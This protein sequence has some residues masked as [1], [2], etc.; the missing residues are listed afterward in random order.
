M[1]IDLVEVRLWGDTVGVLQWEPERNLSVFEYD[2]LFIRSGLNVSPFEAPLSGALIEGNRSEAFDGLPPFIADSLPDRFGNAI[3]NAYFDKAGISKVNLTPLDRLSYIGERAM[4]A[5]TYHPVIENKKLSSNISLQASELVEAAR[6]ALSGHLIDNS[7]EATTALNNLLSVGIS[8]GGARAK[9]VINLNNQTGEIRSGQF[10]CEP[11]FEAWLIK[12]DGV[13]KD[14]ALGSSQHYCRIEYAYSLMAKQAGIE[15]SECCLFEEGGRAHFLTKRFDRDS[16]GEKIHMQTLCAMKGMDFNFNKSHSYEQYFDT[17]QQLLE[18]NS[19]TEQAI[20]RSFFNIIARNQDDHTKNLSFLM[21]KQGRWSLAP[22]Y[23]VTYAFNPDNKWT[24]AHQM[25]LNGKFEGH[26]I[27]DLRAVASRYI[28]ERRADAI[29][30]EVVSSVKKWPL[31]A[32]EA[33]LSKAHSDRIKDNHRR[34]VDN[35]NLDRAEQVL[36]SGLTVKA[37]IESMEQDEDELV[38]KPK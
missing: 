15:M 20:R 5:L 32:E 10:K 35:V 29:L 3:I 24:S 7:D 16:D 2:D 28:S 12:F 19:Q 21:D 26:D 30:D 13:G 17:V 9:A 25:S 38:R 34:L 6:K 23:D 27:N 18:D 22:A 37:H 14:D 11:G 36:Q 1:S 31:F 33:G 8:A 4:G